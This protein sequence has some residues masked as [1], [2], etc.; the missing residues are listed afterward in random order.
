M[1]IISEKDRRALSG[2]HI[3]ESSVRRRLS[4]KE[5]MRRLR[6]LL[7]LTLLVFFGVVLTSAF[8][9]P[10]LKAPAEFPSDSEL[11]ITA[12]KRG[13]LEL[14]WD[15][16]KRTSGY[17]LELYDLSGISDPSTP[18]LERFCRRSRC[19]LQ[20]VDIPAGQYVRVHITARDILYFLEKQEGETAVQEAYWDCYLNEPEIGETREK[21]RNEQQQIDLRWKGWEGDSY[22]LYLKNADGNREMIR[23]FTPTADKAATPGERVVFEE[24]VTYGPRGDFRLPKDNKDYELEMEV[25][26]DMDRVTFQGKT[27]S[28]M[29]VKRADLMSK[30]IVMNFDRLTDNRYRLYWNETGSIGYRL[31]VWEPGTSAYRELAN[32]GGEEELVYETG[33]LA[34]GREYSFRVLA[35]ES[36]DIF[37]A[38]ED[39]FKDPFAAD[40]GERQMSS[41]G[42]GSITFTTEVSP[43]YA[44]IW[45]VR[46]LDLYRSTDRGE[47]IGTVAAQKALCVLAEDRENRLFRVQTDDGEGYIDSDLCMIDLPE[48]VGDLCA[49]DIPNSYSSIYMVN[50]YYIP[51]VTG[52]VTPGYEDILLDDNTFVVPLL[53]PSA[54]KLADAAAATLADGYRI[55]INDSFRPHLATRSIYDETNKVLNWRLP[56]IKYT[57]ITFE[58]FLENGRMISPPTE[59]ALPAGI[60]EQAFTDQVENDAA[61]DAE[62]QGEGAEPVSVDAAQTAPTE[63]AR[64]TYYW[65]MTNGT[66]RL[67]S[68]LAAQASR[69]NLGVAMD[70][71]LTDVNNDGRPLSMQSDMHNLSWYS[72]QSRNNY[73][74][75]LLKG[76]L[77]AAGFGMISSEWWHF[78]DNEIYDAV[79]L[80]VMENGVS[81][82]GWKRD[83]RGWRYRD[84]KG[85]Y[86]TAQT[87]EINGVSYTFDD[88]GY[89]ER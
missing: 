69:H 32:I 55:E 33:H 86:L 28:L 15:P 19:S 70:M 20:S 85:N 27:V 41:S 30:T 35:M 72:A 71:T 50:G 38:E 43:L 75:D 11:T 13:S 64:Y 51:N 67:G 58:R 21:I 49:Y 10:L 80:T 44:T 18:V 31:E 63:N 39:K 61:A 23:E 25:S 59:A 34:P 42:A 40:Q 1:P 26:R 9:L 89:T 52:R 37:G 22:T 73:N 82:E 4:H 56:D 7:I 87:K 62:T 57:G 6:I 2:V 79:N 53:Y 8:V 65:E 54:L 47:K 84:K 76:Y 36:G 74:A 68:F 60:R 24:A 29:T 83:D 88:R 3:G 66:Y 48:Y 45:P 5:R 12:G 81:I 17:R 46:E 77:T 14:S 78:Q 16:G